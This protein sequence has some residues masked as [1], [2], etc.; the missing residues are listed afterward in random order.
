VLQY[1]HTGAVVGG[2]SAIDDRA[3]TAARV[4]SLWDS[5][6]T[7]AMSRCF[8]CGQGSVWRGASLIFP[9]ENTYPLPHRDMPGPTRELYEE[10][11]VVAARSPRAGAALAR[12]A[13]EKLLKEVRPDDKGNLDERIAALHDNVGTDLWAG[14]TVLRHVGN[15]ALHGSDPTDTVVALV[16]EDEDSNAL[17]LL[18]ELI[19]Q[20]VDD[21]LSKPKR[22]RALFDKL[23][24]DV[25]KAALKKAG[26]ELP[27]IPP[28]LTAA[29]TVD[30]ADDDS[31]H[32]AR[33]VDTAPRLPG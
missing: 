29:E 27:E 22:T 31:Q 28:G 33:A 3:P 21:L 16:L 23:P 32:T 10:A 13:L 17:D 14:L 18:F 7:W 24:G 19:N 20:L 25:A 26:I 2:E 15:K 9:E 11:R 6:P 5:R 30:G 1:D 4:T 12:A 8:S